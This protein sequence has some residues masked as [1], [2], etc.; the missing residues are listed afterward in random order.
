VRPL[1]AAN[2]IG[3]LE[4]LAAQPT[5]HRRLGEEGRLEVLEQQRQVEDLDVLLRGRR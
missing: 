1:V 5:A 4:Q 3:E 2:D